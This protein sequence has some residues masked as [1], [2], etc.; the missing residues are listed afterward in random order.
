MKQVVIDKSHEL[1]TALSPTWSSLIPD[2]I[3]AIVTGLAV[4]AVLLLADHR[5]SKR[6]EKVRCERIGKRL[7]HPL[8]LVMQRPEYIHPRDNIRALSKKHQESLNILEDPDLDDWHESEK[9][10]ITQS[11]IK[12][13]NALR[14]QLHDRNDLAQSIDYWNKLHARHSESHSYIEARFSGANEQEL[15]NLFPNKEQREILASD[16][17]RARQ[18]R[19]VKL[20]ARA[21]R[22]ALQRTAKMQTIAY[23]E[24]I[25]QIQIIAPKQKSDN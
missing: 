8:L 22:S 5:S 23:H 14:D 7:I 9:S 2:L 15:R 3:V 12:Y 6:S 11:L 13:R 4:G 10:T 25:A 17:D 21:F 1:T 20:H 16:Y 19:L 18:H 24:L